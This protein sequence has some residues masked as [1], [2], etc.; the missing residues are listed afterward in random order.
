MKKTVMINISGISFHIDED[1]FQLLSQYIERLKSHFYGQES[2]EEILGDIESRIAEI[3]QSQRSETKQVV[4]VADVI[5]VIG[6]M[7]QPFEFEPAENPRMQTEIPGS[8]KGDKRFFRN[9]DE[10]IIAGVCSGIAAYFHLDPVWVRLIFIVFIAAGGSGILLYIALWFVIPE[11]QRTTEK[12]EMRG[13]KINISNIEK[14]IRE[15][16]SDLGNRIGKAAGK[17]A[18]TIRRAGSGS[19][20]IFESIGLIIKSALGWCWKVIII[21]TGIILM[22]FGLSIL[23]ALT[24]Y[25]FGWTTGIYENNEFSLLPFPAMVRMLVGCNMPVGYLQIILIALLGIPFLA[26]FYNGLRMVFRFD[27]IRYLGLTAFNIWIVTLFAAAFFAMK[28]YNLY[29]FNEEKQLSIALEKPDA[30]TLHISLLA[31]D[32]GMK[33][34]KYDKYVL[35]GDWK[36]VITRE[37]EFFLL[38]R[39]RFEES[40]DSLFSVSEIILA[41]GKSRAEALEHITG[42]RYN[43]TSNSNRLNISPYA[44]IPMETCWRGQG[45]NLLIKVPRG[46]YVHLDRQLSDL[47]PDWYYISDAPGGTILQMKDYYLE[48][49][50]PVE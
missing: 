50:R 12:L 30:D 27:R 10:K 28:I 16:V 41:R 19:G 38:P 21:L 31:D 33:Y 18:G 46:K 3:L 9:P 26:L 47:K 15:E 13:E 39:I 6:T 42:I 45:V 23:L 44:R 32:P 22:L 1:A 40:P 37:K 14:S 24:A 5:E 7:G 34:L 2:A 17:S 20:R 11:A 43:I 8:E 29:E 49:I 35:A 36:T 4:T 48:E 25:V